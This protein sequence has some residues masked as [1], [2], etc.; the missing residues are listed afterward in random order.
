MEHIEVAS[1]IVEYV[2]ETH[3]SMLE[4]VLLAI[5]L[6]EVL[7]YG[8]QNGVLHR[9]LKP[10]NILVGN[11]GRPKVIDFGVAG[12]LGG[13]RLPLTLATQAGDILGTLA[14]MSPE[15]CGGD[16]RTADAR[17]D[18]YALGAVIYEMFTHAP[19]F[20]L[21]TKTIPDAIQTVIGGMPK[22]PSS[23]D[24]Q[25]RGD[26]DAIVMKSLER[27]PARRYQS[28]ADFALDL[29]A[30]LDG[31]PV[32]A[33]KQTWLY[34]SERFVRRNWIAIGSL[35]LVIRFCFRPPWCR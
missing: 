2:R 31:L 25:L 29:Q 35:T 21:S 24:A 23:F 13:D 27:E 34:R 1:T 17:A 30:Y 9:D 16:A 33:R 12:S 5:E 11:D 28:A 20:D 32:R 7:Q 22:L 18:T 10:S 15:Q 8:H 4:L 26:L 3:V 19:A 14:Y 6:C